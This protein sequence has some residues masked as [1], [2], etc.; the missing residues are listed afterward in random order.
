MSEKKEVIVIITAGFQTNRSFL[1][2]SLGNHLSSLGFE[3]DL[4]D[5]RHEDTECDGS[6]FKGEVYAPDRPYKYVMTEHYVSTPIQMDPA[7][8]LPPILVRP[9]VERYWD[10]FETNI[11]VLGKANTGKSTLLRLCGDFL[12]SKEVDKERVDYTGLREAYFAEWSTEELMYL[13]DRVK[14]VTKVIIH[15][16]QSRTSEALEAI[17]TTTEKPKAEQAA[18]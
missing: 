3:V 8:P 2:R 6:R 12:L 4:S 13:V 11:A 5:V 10:R 1:A 9:H 7:R 14:E 16:R 17:L 15:T 18:E